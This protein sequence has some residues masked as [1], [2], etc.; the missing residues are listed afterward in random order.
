MAAVLYTL[1]E[2]AKVSGVDPIAYLVEAATLAKREAGAVL[3]PE[4]FRAAA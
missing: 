1:V 2:T 3:L 4:D